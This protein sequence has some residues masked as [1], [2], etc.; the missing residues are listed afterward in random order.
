MKIEPHRL[1][2][3][4]RAEDI[5]IAR[6][7]KRLRLRV[8]CLTGE[9]DV[10]CRMYHSLPEAV[11]GFSKNVTHFFGNSSPAAILYWLVTTLGFVAFLVAGRWDGLWLWIAY[12]LLT[13]I[14]VS[15]A[16]GMNVGDNLLLLLPQQLMLGAF[17]LRSLINKRKKTF[18][19]KG[20]NI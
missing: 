16:A 4:S 8:S 11:G 15:L 20:R 19:W 12:T 14:A 3:K 6:H 7:L 18:F 5:D 2:R 13:R 9:R 17:I 1:F 10:R